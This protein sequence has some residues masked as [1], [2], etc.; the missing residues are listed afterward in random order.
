MSS[1]ANRIQTII[2]DQALVL[3]SRG[4]DERDMRDIAE[5]L[6]IELTVI[7]SDENLIDELEA[8]VAL[9]P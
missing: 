5:A 7:G 6:E 8:A 3:S 1:I 4:N 2:D 9:L